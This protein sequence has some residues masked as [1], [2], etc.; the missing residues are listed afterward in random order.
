MPWFLFLFLKVQSHF[1]RKLGALSEFLENILFFCS[2]TKVKTLQCW[3]PIRM[4]VSLNMS[5][6]I[7]QNKIKLLKTFHLFSK[8]LFQSEEMQITS[9]MTQQKNRQQSGH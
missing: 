9:G 2:T 7:I 1:N 8:R 4:L 5:L 3:D 6:F